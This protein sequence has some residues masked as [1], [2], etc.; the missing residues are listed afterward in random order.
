MWNF[1]EQPWTLL[2]TAVV[3]LLVVAV[4]SPFIHPRSKRLL[5]LIPL[6]VAVMGPVLDF[7]VRTDRE[8]IEKVIEVGVKAFENEDCGAIAA[9][10]SENYRDSLHADKTAFVQRCRAVLRPPAVSKVYD[11]IMDMQ[12][13]GNTASLTMLNRIFFDEQSYYAELRVVAVK[14]QIDLE[15]DPDGNWLVTRT[16]VLAVNNQPTKWSNI[17]YR[18]W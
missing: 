4:I 8:K 3:L 5:W 14:V 2:I 10:I 1:F 6:L 15:K 13:S 11:S 16:E 18:N 12:V 7:A 17:N 9:I